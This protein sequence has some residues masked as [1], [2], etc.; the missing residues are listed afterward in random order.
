MK[1]LSGWRISKRGYAQPPASAFDGEGSR[2]RQVESGGEASGVR[3]QQL[4][5]GRA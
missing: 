3:I 1:G 2:R 4:G 5:V